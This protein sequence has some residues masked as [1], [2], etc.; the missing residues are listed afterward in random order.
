MIEDRL[1]E[2][3]FTY[4]EN[5]ESYN[6]NGVV[7]NNGYWEII[8]SNGGLFSLRRISDE[9][10]EATLQHNIWS[11]LNLTND[12]LLEAFNI[13]NIKIGSVV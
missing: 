5:C 11:Y 4:V 3:G 9:I 6:P 13:L 2:L 8:N 10:W 7:S 12:N 1:K